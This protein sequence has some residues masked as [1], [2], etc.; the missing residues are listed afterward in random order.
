MPGN[1]TDEITLG[2]NPN[3]NF[4]EKIKDKRGIMV[5]AKRGVG[6]DYQEKEGSPL[7]EKDIRRDAPGMRWQEIQYIHD[8][9]PSPDSFLD[10]EFAYVPYRWEPEE[11][12]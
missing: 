12:D 5:V 2:A 3:V 7:L 6:V 11:D 4:T 9:N 8:P 1:W 10:E